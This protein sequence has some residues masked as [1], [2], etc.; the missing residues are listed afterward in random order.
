MRLAQLARMA[1]QGG[2]AAVELEL[3]AWRRRGD[4]PTAARVMLAGLLAQR[5][6]CDTAL[7]ILEEAD[8]H[9]A[10]ALR[11]RIALLLDQDRLTDAKTCVEQLYHEHGYDPK[12]TM[13]LRGMEAPGVEMLPVVSDAV[14]DT[15]AGELI[16]RIELVHSLVAAQKVR[17]ELRSVRL[18]R[19]A[20]RTMARDVAD[21]RQM[22]TVCEAVA[23]LSLL[24]GDEDEAR[25][26]A[27]R[28]LRLEPYYAPLAMVL[29]RV[30]D[31]VS[32]GPPA[33]QVLSATAEHH[34]TYRDVLAALIRRQFA[35]GDHEAA[36][37]RLQ[38]WHREEPHEPIVQTLK[39]E[40]AA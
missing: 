16:G 7:T 34:P 9:D 10:E 35:E 14:V 15:L 36:R 37:A 27:H 11:L 39:R 1:Q 3:H 20:I 21:R 24:L 6:R 25:R 22:V 31:D 23:E 32:V 29:S 18:L 28:G 13:W 2:A 17:P 19:E 33:T 12:V 26:W 4:C 8:E 30:E 38:R 5:G 40:L